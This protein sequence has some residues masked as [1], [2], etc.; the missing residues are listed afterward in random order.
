MTQRNRF[1]RY[2]EVMGW[3]IARLEDGYYA[4]AKMNDFWA[5]WMG[6]VEFDNDT[7]G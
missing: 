2:A 3:D 7:T 1:E 4:E 5:L 6:C